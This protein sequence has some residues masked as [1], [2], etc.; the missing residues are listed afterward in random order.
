MTEGGIPFW[1]KRK[2]KSSVWNFSSARGFLQYPKKGEK[3]RGREGGDGQEIS[4]GNFFLS[5]KEEKLSL[6]KGK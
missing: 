4:K 3:I 6:L 2:R 1:G 5:K